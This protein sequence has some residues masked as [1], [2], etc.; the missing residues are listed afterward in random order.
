MNDLQNQKDSFDTSK[1]LKR[2]LQKIIFN[3]KEKV[4]VIEVY[5]KNMKIIEDAFNQIKEVSGILDIEEIANTFIK[6]EEQNHSLYKYADNLSQQ[7]DKL[8][9]D[10]Q[11][12]RQKIEMYKQEL[13]DKNKFKDQ[14][15]T[16]KQ[17][18]IE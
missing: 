11:M 5:N 2:R 3:N 13:E 17:H 6:S 9:L 16:A 15:T 1:L 8:E 12:I 7:I 10:N 18:K 4:K 14:D